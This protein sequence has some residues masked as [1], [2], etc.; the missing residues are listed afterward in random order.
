MIKAI[1]ALAVSTSIFLPGTAFA[2]EATKVYLT[3]YWVCKE[4]KTTYYG[5]R[6]VK[7]VQDCKLK[8]ERTQPMEPPPAKKTPQ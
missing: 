4:W 8:Q 5:P 1:L 2:G 6:C 3:C 7:R